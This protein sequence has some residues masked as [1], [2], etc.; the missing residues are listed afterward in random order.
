MRYFVL[1]GGFIEG[2]RCKKCDK[3]LYRDGESGEGYGRC[4][5]R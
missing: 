4:L 2:E 3:D 5:G 1:N